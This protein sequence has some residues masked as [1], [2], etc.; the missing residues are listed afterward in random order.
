[1]NISNQEKRIISDQLSV[2]EKDV[3]IQQHINQSE[4]KLLGSVLIDNENLI[5]FMPLLNNCIQQINPKQ[6]IYQ[7]GIKW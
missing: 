4:H 7:V 1:M 5:V 6:E 2:N 3:V